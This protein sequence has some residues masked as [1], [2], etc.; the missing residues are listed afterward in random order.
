M[1][2]QRGHSR[3]L[4]LVSPQSKHSWLCPWPEHP[5]DHWKS[6]QRVYPF[7][8]SRQPSWSHV[9]W[10]GAELSQRDDALQ[11]GQPGQVLCILRHFGQVGEGL[12][13]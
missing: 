8:L 13:L 9:Q 10:V 6:Q 11:G 5:Q 7:L 1:R 12:V 3:A 2:W 4:W